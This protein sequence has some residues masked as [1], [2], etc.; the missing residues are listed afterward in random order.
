M[1]YSVY[2][3]KLL[4]ALCDELGLIWR[5]SASGITQPSCPARRMGQ[6]ARR[7]RI[8]DSVEYVWW[9]SPTPWPSADNRRVLVP[10]SGDMIRL[11]E[12]GYKPKRRPSG[13]N[14]TA[15]FRKNQ[16]GAIPSNL[17]IKGNK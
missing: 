9:L 8:K 15:K 2:H 17:V 12:R 16:G 5:R 11:I 6:C 7:T 4:I 1:P 10:Y 3:F 14:I 13:H